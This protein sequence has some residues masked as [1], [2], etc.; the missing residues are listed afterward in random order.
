[1]T[2]METPVPRTAFDPPVIVSTELVASTRLAPVR[3]R[4]T[5]DPNT[6]PV[7]PVTTRFVVGVDVRFPVVAAETEVP[8][9][10]RMPVTVV[11]SVM[12]GVVV[13]LATLPAKPLAVAT[14]IDVT[15]P[16][17]PPCGGH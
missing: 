2:A 12:V 8:L 14:L 9:P 3:V 6:D 5:S 7:P 10:W 15:V 13:G 16:D 17:P 1:M 11:L 4:S